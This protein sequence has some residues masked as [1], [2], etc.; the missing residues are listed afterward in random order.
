MRSGTRSQDAH[1]TCP[2]TL[3]PLAKCLW[4][5]GTHK[6]SMPAIIYDMTVAAATASS[7]DSKTNYPLTRP[8]KNVAS[9]RWCSFS[10]FCQW[11]LVH[12]C[13]AHISSWMATSFKCHLL[14]LFNTLLTTLLK[15]IAYTKYVHKNKRAMGHLFV[16]VNT[17][18]YIMK[19]PKCDSWED[20]LQIVY[21]TVKASP[22]SHDSFSHLRHFSGNSSVWV[23]AAVTLEIEREKKEKGKRRSEDDDACRVV[24]GAVTRNTH[25]SLRKWKRVY[26]TGAA[27]RKRQE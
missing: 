21:F 9:E 24:T 19:Q 14:L 13:V 11:T 4:H 1:L 2:S 10:F 17:I 18:Q 22:I 23:A 27:R 25:Y 20:T 15:S 6:L 5:C 7:N 16:W 8:S 26:T 3:V 12:S